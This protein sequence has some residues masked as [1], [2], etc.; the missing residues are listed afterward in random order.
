MPINSTSNEEF[1]VKILEDQQKVYV[2]FIRLIST[3]GAL[4]SLCHIEIYLS[5]LDGGRSWQ[6]SKD[7]TARV[8][9]GV[10]AVQGSSC[11]APEMT[12]RLRR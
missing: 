4:W 10:I 11:H 3:F 2:A 5:K 7:P 6:R 9:V 8:N 12:T 1:S